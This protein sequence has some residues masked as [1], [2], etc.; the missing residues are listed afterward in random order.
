MGKRRKTLIERMRSGEF[1]VSIQIDPPGVSTDLKEFQT[2]IKKLIEVGAALFDI[3]SSR[4]ISHDSVELAVALARR[5]IDVI[6]HVTTRDS[7][8]NGL[9]N[10]AFAAYS[11]SKVSDFLIITGDPYEAEKAIIPSRGVFQTDS[12]GALKAFDEYLRKRMGL[13][14]AL[15]AAVNQNEPDLEYEGIRI[16]EKESAGADFF[17]SQPIFSAL[18]AM[19]LLNFYHRY[20]KRPLLVGVWPLVYRK[21]IE[22]IKNAKIVGVSLPKEVYEESLKF[23][24]REDALLEWGLEGALRL[25]RFLKNDGR[26][27]GV[28]IVAPSRNPQVLLDILPD[29]L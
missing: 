25:I 15:G 9:L 11:L 19:E 16:Q 18:Q 22:A 2:T 13:G 21:T 23:W 12:I 5:K 7:S 3:N 26:A 10:Q 27:S 29:I 4:R 6:P 20:S 24:E 17:M 14:I 1:L 28:Y 8:I